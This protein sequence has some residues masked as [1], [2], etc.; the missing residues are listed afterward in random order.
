MSER[1]RDQSNVRRYNCA[2]GER[3]ERIAMHVSS[4]KSDAS[5]SLLK[6][7]EHLVTNPDVRFNSQVEVEV[8]T[9]DAWAKRNNIGAVDFLWLDL[10]GHE[11]GA[12]R[13][14]I[15][16]LRGVKVIHAEVS[17]LEMY[18]GSA[19]YHEVRAWLSDQG[20]K[21]GQYSFPWEDHG[22]V[23]FVRK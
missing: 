9:L 2:L 8:A 14:G 10:Q 13:G 7:K 11:L 6:P 3:E 5:S 22:E 23:L 12:L 1:T 17:L 16:L 18:E 21:I 4:G 19:L 20:F 15:E